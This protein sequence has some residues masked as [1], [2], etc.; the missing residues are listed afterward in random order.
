MSKDENGIF[1]VYDEY[2][3]KKMIEINK[4]VADYSMNSN[5]YIDIKVLLEEVNIKS[6]NIKR[7]YSSRKI[8]VKEKK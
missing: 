2:I 5:D 1:L 7:E 8:L 4:K 3:I 6:E